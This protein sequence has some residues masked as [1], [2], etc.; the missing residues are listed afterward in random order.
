MFPLWSV[1]ALLS[2]LLATAMPLLQE[3]YKADGF[4]LALW[5]KIFSVLFSFPYILHYGLPQD[6]QFYLYVGLTAVLFSI[7]DIIY[8]RAVPVIG[9]GLITRLLPSSVV[10]TFFLWFIFDPSLITKYAAQPI[11][12]TLIGLTLLLFTYCASHVKRCAVSW[13][14]VRKIW[15]VIF[16]ACLGPILCKLAVDHATKQQAPLAFIFVQAS[17]MALILS[18]TFVVRKPITSAVLFSR[19]SI[20]TGFIIGCVMAVMVYLKTKSFQLVDNPGFSSMLMFTDSLWVLLVYRLIG[21]KEESNV[22]AGLGIVV[23]AAL[24]VLIKN[25]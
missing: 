20:K 17:M 8:F 12:T 3:R 19:N 22:W 7:S 14:G 23:C 13:Q 16:A 11:K 9:S 2:A 18:T 15:F 1:Y 24:V 10:I 5:V 6:W 21:R 25:F 4:S